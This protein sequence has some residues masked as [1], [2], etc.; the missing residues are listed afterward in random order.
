MTR[1]EVIQAALNA[2][3]TDADNFR[4][5]FAAGARAMADALQPEFGSMSERIA[6]LELSLSRFP[7]FPSVYCSQC[8]C[9]FGP[10][11][12]GF[13]HCEDHAHLVAR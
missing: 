5:G 11:D 7:R 4:E 3:E 13:S 6:D 9:N 1:T 12:H 2:A 8:G 10:G